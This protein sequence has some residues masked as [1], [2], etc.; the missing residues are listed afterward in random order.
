MMALGVK[1]TGGVTHL[2]RS[3]IYQEPAQPKK[4]K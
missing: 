2:H 4:Y 1:N 3:E